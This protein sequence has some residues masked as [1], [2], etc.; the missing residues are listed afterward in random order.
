[1]EDRPE[2]QKR[3]YLNL[4]I[5]GEE[6]V[7]K[8]DLMK[9]ISKNGILN[10]DPRLKDIIYQLEL[11]EDYKFTKE[12]F[13]KIMESNYDIIFKSMSEQFVIPEFEKV[14]GQIKDL[15]NLCNKNKS[16]KVADYIPELATAD[17]NH[18]GV[19][20]CSVDG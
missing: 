14:K 5:E 6:A 9:Q 13:F 10:D 15:Y 4:K 19:S 1:M 11:I 20:I 2:I 8:K 17:P 3:I 16:G 18:F 7:L 12:E